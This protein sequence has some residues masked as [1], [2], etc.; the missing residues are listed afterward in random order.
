[1]QFRRV[2]NAIK[3]KENI[4]KQRLPC[5]SETKIFTFAHARKK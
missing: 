5:L 4:K 3:E 1:V 2:S